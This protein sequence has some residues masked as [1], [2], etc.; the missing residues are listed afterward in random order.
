[1]ADLAT[2]KA[3]VIALVNTLLR[4]GRIPEMSQLDRSTFERTYA[5]R[6]L[7]LRPEDLGR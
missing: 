4:L 5:Q 3:E 1:M 2:H 7:I 6:R